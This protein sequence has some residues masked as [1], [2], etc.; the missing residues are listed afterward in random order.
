MVK[1][2]LV[3]AVSRLV[4]VV[5]VELPHEGGEVVVFEVGGQ[6]LVNELRQVFHHE[7]LAIVHPADDLVV[8]DI[9]L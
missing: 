3:V 9:L 2:V 6:H 5:H 8:V 1:G 7:G 4:E